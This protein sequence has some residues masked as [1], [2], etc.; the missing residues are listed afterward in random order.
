M[1]AQRSR[2][3]RGRNSGHLAGKVRLKEPATGNALRL[4]GLQGLAEG[5][6]V[7]HAADNQVRMDLV[8]IEK[9]DRRLGDGMAGL[10]D[11][12][13]GREVLADQDVNM[14]NL[15]CHACSPFGHCPRQDSN[16][17]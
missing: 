5:C 6:L 7:G 17:H 8:R 9:C 13:S 1:S 16:P 4:D 2:D 10:N 12:L 15:V 3:W 11:L 14:V